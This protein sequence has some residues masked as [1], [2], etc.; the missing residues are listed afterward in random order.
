MVTRPAR[1]PITIR[2]LLTHSVGIHDGFVTSD[3]V[4]G[5]LDQRAGV[6]YDSRLLLADK[7]RH[8]PTKTDRTWR[9]P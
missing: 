9:I 1:R 8:L 6:V 7:I 2:Q 3:L 5:R 4:M